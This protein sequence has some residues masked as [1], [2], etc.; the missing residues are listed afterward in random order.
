MR[1]RQ[2]KAKTTRGTALGWGPEG[3]PRWAVALVLGVAAAAAGQDGGGP[4]LR[5]PNMDD[6]IR[7]NV[8]ADNW[9][10]LYVN[11][12]L[13]AVDSIAFVPHNVVSVDILP[14]YPMTIAV[15]AKDNADPRTGMEYANTNVGDGGFIL[16]FGDGTVTDGTWKVRRF[17]RGPVDGDTDQP[18]VEET[19]LPDDWFA[20]DFDDHEWRQATEY[21]EE[22][23]GPKQPFFDAD[24]AG[25]RFI[26]SDDL[27]LDNTVVFRRRVEAPPD[28]VDRTD[29]RGLNDV[30]PESPQGRRGPR[31]GRP[32]RQGGAP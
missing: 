24:F 2:R 16:K 17:S 21:T 6:T 3:R 8:Y 31:P 28:G 25:A 12:Q 13:V 29:F 20:V 7:A 32:P 22:D 15:L 9:F 26:W 19:P 1:E 18:R 4:R 23:V 14:A 10:M 30:V 11:G 5:K 27:A